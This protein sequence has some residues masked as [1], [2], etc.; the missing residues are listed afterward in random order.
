MGKLP[1]VISSD[2]LSRRERA[3]LAM[4]NDEYEAPCLCSSVRKSIAVAIGAE[5]GS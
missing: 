2:T 3:D 1:N 4:H 5:E